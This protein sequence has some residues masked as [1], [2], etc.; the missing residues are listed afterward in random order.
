MTTWVNIITED[1]EP[2]YRNNG[3]YIPG[4]PDVVAT[5]GGNG[6]EWRQAAVA[7]AKANGLQEVGVNGM[8]CGGP[9]EIIEVEEAESFETDADAYAETEAEAESFEI[10]ADRLSKEEAEQNRQEAW[11]TDPRFGYAEEYS[12][13]AADAVHHEFSDPWVWKGNAAKDRR[14]RQEWREAIAN[15]VSLVDRDKSA[16]WA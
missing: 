6:I 8:W 14:M 11:V 3:G 10:E 16:T 4:A 5:R 12:E 9:D 2:S 7:Y 1:Q 15:A 13:P